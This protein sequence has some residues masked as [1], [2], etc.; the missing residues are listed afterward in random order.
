MRAAV[1][2][3]FQKGDSFSMFRVLAQSVPPWCIIE[4]WPMRTSFTRPEGFA[5]EPLALG[6][7]TFLF[8][9]CTQNVSPSF[10]PPTQIYCQR[11][12]TAGAWPPWHFCSASSFVFVS[13]EI[14]PNVDFYNFLLVF[15]GAD[16]NTPGRS[17]GTF[18]LRPSFIFF[19]EKSR[20]LATPSPSSLFFSW[21]PFP[22]HPIPRF[23]VR[24][25]IPFWFPHTHFLRLFVPTL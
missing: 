8:W 25:P 5:R 3:H 18:W 19:S 16:S 11:R 9:R 2:P 15:P 10:S 13:P 14:F 7:P 20:G 6:S 21:C 4:S 17:D 22:S 1:V 12:G 23:F 24:N